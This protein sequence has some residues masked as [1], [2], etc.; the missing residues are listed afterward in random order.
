MAGTFEKGVALWTQLHSQN[1]G[2]NVAASLLNCKVFHEDFLSKILIFI[3]ILLLI[4]GV[5]FPYFFQLIFSLQNQYPVLIFFAIFL[6]LETND[7]NQ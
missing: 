6:K 2:K 5:S 3:L 7:C 4:F 1:R